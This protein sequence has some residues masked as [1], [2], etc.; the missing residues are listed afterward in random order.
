MEMRAECAARVFIRG[1]SGDVRRRSPLNQSYAESYLCIMLPFPNIKNSV[2]TK[3]LERPAPTCISCVDTP[4]L[5]FSCFQKQLLIE[6]SLLH[7]YLS[8]FVFG[9]GCV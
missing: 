2:V 9:K 3:A 7:R 8:L 5:S 4:L 6:S 1:D